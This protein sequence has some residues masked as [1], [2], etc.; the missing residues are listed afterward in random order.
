MNS[1]IFVKVNNTLSESANV[2]VV[3]NPDSEEEPV[4]QRQY[5]DAVQAGAMHDDAAKPFFFE[6]NK[7][8]DYF[9]EWYFSYR[10]GDHERKRTKFTPC[11]LRSWQSGKVLTLE[12]SEGGWVFDRDGLGCKGRWDGGVP[13]LDL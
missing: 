9:E 12:V 1:Y 3:L 8:K 13:K 7:D 10:V 6:N 2:Q 5:F 4:Q 11:P